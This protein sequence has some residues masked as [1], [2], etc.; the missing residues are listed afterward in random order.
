MKYKGNIRIITVLLLG[1]FWLALASSAIANS[2]PRL[3]ALSRQYVLEGQRLELDI[4]GFD[5]NGDK[6]TLWVTGRPVGAQFTDFGNGTAR[7]VW[8]PEF[9]GPNSSENSPFTITVWASDGVAS[10]SM[11]VDLVVLNNNRPPVVVAPSRVDVQSGQNLEFSMQGS[12][13]DG[14]PLVWNILNLP[15]GAGFNYTNGLTIDW[16]TAYADSGLHTIAVELTDHYGGADTAFVTAAVAQ[17]TVFAISVDTVSGYPGEFT[18]ININ[19]NNLEPVSGFDLLVNYD[20]SSMALVSVTKVGTRSANFEYFTFRMNY[21]SIAG[22]V[23][24]VG[25]A[26]PD[27]NG[28]GVALA[29]GDGPVATLKFMLPS[30]SNYGGFALPINFVF[31]DILE[32][33]DNTMTANDGTRISQSQIKYTNGYALIK[34]STVEGIGDINLN[35][36]AYEIGDAIYLTN[37]LINPAKYPLNAK[38]RLNS[39]VNRDGLTGTVADLV[40]LILKIVNPGAYPKP[41]VGNPEAAFALDGDGLTVYSPVEL[42]AV[43]VT[44][45][46]VSDVEAY[47]SSDLNRQGLLVKYGRDGRTLR[48]L[49][50]SDEGQVLPSGLNEIFKI[51]NNRVYEIKEVQVSSVDGQILAATTGGDAVNVLPSGFILHQNYPNPFNPA[52]EIKFDLPYSARVEVKVFNVLGQEITILLDRELPS[53]SHSVIWDGRDGHGLAVSSGIYFYRLEADGHSI[54]KKMILIK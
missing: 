44:L 13:P 23:N 51:E 52:T 8:T 10:T 29:A 33:K 43:A 27:G 19:L 1:A 48:V 7:L 32:A 20:A 22:D 2:A 6:V 45:E 36:I 46:L 9:S 26:D 12:D 30:S 31:R 38:Q 39:D 17:T 53:G 21:R 42:G 5:D 34:E 49:V 47:I 41:V 35:G 3:Q 24:I 37:F 14:D 28:P 18:D 25:I 50:Y 16:P 11:N 15:S 54:S 4:A 40:Y